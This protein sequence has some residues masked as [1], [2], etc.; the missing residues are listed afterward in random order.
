MPAFPWLFEVKATAEPNEAVVPLPADHA[1]ASGVV[2][3]DARGRAL[4]ADLLSRRQVPIQGYGGT[5]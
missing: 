3:P 1:P 4:V 2:V 5:R